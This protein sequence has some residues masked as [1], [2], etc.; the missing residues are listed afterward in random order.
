MPFPRFVG[1]GGHWGW[2]S[3]CLG[4]SLCLP[5]AGNKAG[6]LDVT[7]AMESVVP[8]PFRFACCLRARSV[9]RPCAQ[10]RVRLSIAVP[11][12]AGGRGVE[13]GPAPASLPGAAVLTGG[14]GITATAL[15]RMGAGV[16]VACG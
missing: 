3:P 14:G 13:A 15:G 8:I 1:P 5:W 9:W 10:A 7:L 2:G 12:G 4:L 11:A 6:V 16:P